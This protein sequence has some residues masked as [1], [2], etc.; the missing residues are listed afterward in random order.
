[1]VGKGAMGSVWKAQ[2]RSQIVAVKK[3]RAEAADSTMVTGF[4]Q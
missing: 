4:L 3:I 2:W 1:M